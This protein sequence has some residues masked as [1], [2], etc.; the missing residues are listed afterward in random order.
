MKK[1]E[2]KWSN[3]KTRS[4]K[5]S[6]ERIVYHK[7]KLNMHIKRNDIS[8]SYVLFVAFYDSFV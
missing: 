3:N 1:I 2:Q 8:F 6:V 5:N 7:K 4:K